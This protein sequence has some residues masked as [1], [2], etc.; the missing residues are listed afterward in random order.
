M[1]RSPAS[2]QD[3]LPLFVPSGLR[4]PPK[5]TPGLDAEDIYFDEGLGF[6]ASIDIDCTIVDG[7]KVSAL[8]TL[9]GKL[10]LV[11]LKHNFVPCRGFSEC[12]GDNNGQTTELF[13]GE[14]GHW[15]MKCRFQ[16]AQ[17]CTRLKALLI[18]EL[19]K[20]VYTAGLVLSSA[21]P[22]I[23]TAGKGTLAVEALVELLDE[24]EIDK[25][26]TDP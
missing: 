24:V 13:I 6:E 19:Q 26:S 7:V 11:M 10:G 1:S 2:N 21:K 8:N 4:I 14:I 17:E 5:E 23:L 3:V 20:G 25:V 12:L 16:D 22:W 18:S 9:F 15:Q